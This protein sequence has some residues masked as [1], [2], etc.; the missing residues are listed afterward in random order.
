MELIN[1]PP[2]CK[3]EDIHTGTTSNRLEDSHGHQFLESIAA[4]HCL[5]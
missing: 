2:G 4:W 1:T 3:E 5:S